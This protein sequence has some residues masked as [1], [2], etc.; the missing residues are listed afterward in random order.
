MDKYVHTKFLA[1]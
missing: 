1:E